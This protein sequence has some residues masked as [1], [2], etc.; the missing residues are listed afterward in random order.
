MTETTR[1]VLLGGLAVAALAAAVNAGAAMNATPPR[2]DPPA[3]TADPEAD[4]SAGDGHI[5]PA[6]LVRPRPARAS[7]TV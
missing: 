3:T 1:A 7:V 5:Q 4:G 6:W 2:P